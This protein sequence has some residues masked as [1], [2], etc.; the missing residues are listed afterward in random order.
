M[1][2][3]TSGSEGEAGAGSPV[4]GPGEGELEAEAGAFGG[5]QRLGTWEKP[6]VSLT[7]CSGRSPPGSPHTGTASEE[8]PSDCP[9][10]DPGRCQ[11]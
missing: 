2:T 6:Q 10:G 3:P 7:C 1:D 5:R 9:P 8:A 4:L 11:S